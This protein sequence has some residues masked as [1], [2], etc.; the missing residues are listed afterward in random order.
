MSASFFQC[1]KGLS[2]GFTL[3]ELM[4]VLAILAIVLVIAAPSFAN[5][6][7]AQRIKAASSDIVA[8]LAYARSEAIK[9]N[10][11]VTITP[12]SGNWASGWTIT[13]SSGVLQSQS[14]YQRI[15]VTGPTSI[16]FGRSGRVISSVATPINIDDADG[17]PAVTGRCIT[18]GVSGLPRAIAGS[19]S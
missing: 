13:S 16:V 1:R 12:T 17:R 19:C 14:G 4:V 11:S 15:T 10:G 5:F 7:L 2:R 18:L 9:Q 3:I 8:S 6:I